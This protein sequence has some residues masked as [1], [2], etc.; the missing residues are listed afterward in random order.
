MN[1]F[2]NIM[3]F[4]NLMSGILSTY[5]DEDDETFML[6]VQSAPWVTPE[7]CVRLGHH[8]VLLRLYRTHRA[9]F[10]WVLD[11]EQAHIPELERFIHENFL[12]RCQCT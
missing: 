5:I 7:A 4:A 8:A 2:V 11:H 6:F 3:D 12:C 1:E 9:N 10:G